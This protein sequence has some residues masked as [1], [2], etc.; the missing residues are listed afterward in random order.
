MGHRSAP[1]LFVTALVLGVVAAP[2]A[3][4]Q[5]AVHVVE[6]GDTLWQIA[7]DAG[8]DVATLMNLNGLEE[9]DVIVV[10]HSL[11]LPPPPSAAP[12]ANRGNAAT[13]GAGAVAGSG[14]AASSAPSTSAAS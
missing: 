4:A 11:K 2:A 8:V 1:F 14:G 5:S 7:S 6:T 3:Q 12:A 9:G 10:G 13:G